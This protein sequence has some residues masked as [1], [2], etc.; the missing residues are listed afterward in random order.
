[1]HS[2]RKIRKSTIF[3][4]YFMQYILNADYFLMNSCKSLG[5]KLFINPD[6]EVAPSH[7]VFVRFLAGVLAAQN[8]VPLGRKESQCTV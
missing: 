6:R 8:S 3:G 4:S 1:M 2:P 7:G 5:N